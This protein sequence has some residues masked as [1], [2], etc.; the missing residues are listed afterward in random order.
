M[1]LPLYRF[2][3]S[4]AQS[5]PVTAHKST[6]EQ[7]GNAHAT[8]HNGSSG[9]RPGQ[10][11]GADIL[12][13]APLLVLTF[14]RAGLRLARTVCLRVS[15]SIKSIK[16]VPQCVTVCLEQHPTPYGV[17]HLHFSPGMMVYW[18]WRLLKQH[19]C[20]VHGCVQET[21]CCAFAA[22]P[23]AGGSKR[24]QEGAPSLGLLAAIQRT[25]SLL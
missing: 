19:F 10:A 4:P 3:D 22:P 24:L 13:F 14:S 20:R 23:S 15:S 9:A 25:A 21:V 16:R 7:D 6:G 5:N 18:H 2:S 12:S 1:Y 17:F 8:T 11:P